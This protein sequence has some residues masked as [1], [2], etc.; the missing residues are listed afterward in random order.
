[1]WRFKFRNAWEKLPFDIWPTYWPMAYFLYF[2][3]PLTRIHLYD[4]IFGLYGLKFLLNHPSPYNIP[5]F[6]FRNAWEKLTFD[7]RTTDQPTANFD[8]FPE[9]MIEPPSRIFL[10]F[11]ISGPYELK[12]CVNHPSPYS[13]WRKKFGNLWVKLTFDHRTTEQPTANFYFSL[14]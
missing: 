1:M 5:W 14:R 9:I 11:L 2:L 8:I 3:Q 4:F 13:M 10:H 12:F 7:H 6:K